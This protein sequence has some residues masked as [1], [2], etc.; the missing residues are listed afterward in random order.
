MRLYPF[1][2]NS[3]R[4]LPCS[5]HHPCSWKPSCQTFQNSSSPHSMPLACSF[6]PPAGVI[7]FPLKSL[8]CV[9]LCLQYLHSLSYRMSAQNL[10]CTN[11]TPP[12]FIITEVSSF[13]PTTPASIPPHKPLQMLSLLSVIITPPNPLRRLLFPP[14]RTQPQIVPPLRKFTNYLPLPQPLPLWPKSSANI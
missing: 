11:M 13:I 2:L 7:F 14:F 4:P 3:P 12:V 9:T 10:H 5:G 1:L 6:H 8:W